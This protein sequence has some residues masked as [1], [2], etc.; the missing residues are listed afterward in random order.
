MI[1]PLSPSKEPLLG[2]PRFMF[3]SELTTK[4]SLLKKLNDIGA[5]SSVINRSSL[6]TTS[7]TKSASSRFWSSAT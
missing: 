7:G 5:S 4:A 6:A 1:L 3:I 2:I